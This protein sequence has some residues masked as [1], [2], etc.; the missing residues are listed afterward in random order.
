MKA[1]SVYL[2]G[3][4]TQQDCAGIFRETFRR[5]DRQGKVP[6]VFYPAV[7]IPTDDEL[8]EAQRTWRTVLPQLAAFM[9]GKCVF[10]S[11]NRFER[12]KV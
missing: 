8:A 9:E 5:L 3:M 11:I 7:P 6:E 2:A 10:L 12:K 4:D 1:H